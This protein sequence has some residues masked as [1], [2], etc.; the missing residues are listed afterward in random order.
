MFDETGFTQC[1]EDLAGDITFVF[2]SLKLSHENELINKG[3]CIGD[4][5]GRF[6]SSTRKGSKHEVVLDSPGYL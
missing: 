5:P 2:L 1:Q 4:T 3:K 6:Q